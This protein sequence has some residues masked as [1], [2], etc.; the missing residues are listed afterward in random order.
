MHRLAPLTLLVFTALVP[1]RSEPSPPPSPPAWL[2]PVEVP[3]Q[4]VRPF[5]APATDYGAGHRGI[6]IAAGTALLAPADGIVHFAGVVV[7]RPV[8]SI[9]HG[10]GVLSSFEAVSSELHKGDPVHRGDEIGTIEP[11]HCSIDCVHV[12]VRVNGE[13]VSPLLYLGGLERSVLLPTRRIAIEG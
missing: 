4:I 2:W 1:V 3:R 13:Y 9:D 6:D 10:G 5:L 7:D 11:G 12:G 8:L